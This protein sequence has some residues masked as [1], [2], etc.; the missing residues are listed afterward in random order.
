MKKCKE[1]LAALHGLTKVF[2]LPCIFFFQSC[3]L[4]MYP[5]VP[6]TFVP[7]S[8]HLRPALN[9]IYLFPP[10]PGLPFH[11]NMLSLLKLSFLPFT[12]HNCSFPG[13]F[14]T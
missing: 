2:F 10:S 11:C 14:S 12:P 1:K 5:S 7:H 3:F 8:F 9:K 4:L 6:Q 13:I